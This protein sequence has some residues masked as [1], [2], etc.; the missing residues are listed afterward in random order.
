MEKVKVLIKEPYKEPYVKEVDDTLKSF[1]DI[2]GGYIEYVPYTID[3]GITMFCNDSGL[4]ENLDGNL[5]LAGT[6][7]CIVGTCYFIG[8]NEETGNNLSLTDEQIN[9][10]KGY[11]DK[12]QIPIGYDLYVDYSQLRKKMYETYRKQT[13][14]MEM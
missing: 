8:Y 6:D 5:W 1:Q 9:K 13:K 14:E 2:V 12:Y 10:V 4:I 11:I 3:T 7:E